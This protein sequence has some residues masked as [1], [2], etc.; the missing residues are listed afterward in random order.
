[1]KEILEMM[2]AL[3]KA[4]F[5]LIFAAAGALIIAGVKIGEWLWKLLDTWIQKRQGAKEARRDEGEH[6][7]SD[8]HS[9]W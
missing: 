9:Y 6:G 8:S 4:V 5:M 3:L 1:M 2:W 7:R